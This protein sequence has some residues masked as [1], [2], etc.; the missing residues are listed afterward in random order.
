MKQA[1]WFLGLTATYIVVAGVAWSWAL[2]LDFAAWK[3][4]VVGALSAAMTLTMNMM[5]R[6]LDFM[7]R[8]RAEINED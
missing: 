3:L 5:M 8:P 1:F 4:F 7:T 6:W 2:S